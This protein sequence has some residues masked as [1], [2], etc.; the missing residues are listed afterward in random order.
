MGR[1]LVCLRL[2]QLLLAAA[3]PLPARVRV[4]QLGRQLITA[5]IAELL[6]SEASAWAASASIRSTCSRIEA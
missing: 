4:N 2:F 1:L 6:I 3:Q 5:R